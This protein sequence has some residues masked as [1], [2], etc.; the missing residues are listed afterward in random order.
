VSV[1]R[2]SR[3][4]VVAVG[5]TLAYVVAAKLGLRLAFVTPTAT[6]VWPPTGIALAALLVFGTRLWPAVFIGA[7]I[8]DASA[9]GSFALMLALAMGNTLEAVAG[10]WLVRRLARGAQAFDCARDVFG[11]AAITALLSTPISA[12]IGATSLWI[13]G[14]VSHADYGGVWLTWWLGDASAD[15][16]VAPVLILWAIR[17]RLS[18]PSARQ[19]ERIL[20]AMGLGIAGPVIFADVLQEPRMAY[21][22]MFVAFPFLSWAVF[23]FGAREASTAMAWLSAVAIWGV[24]HRLG[25]FVLSTPNASLLLLQSFMALTSV[26]VLST[27]GVVEERNRIEAEL[28]RQA[29]TDPLTGLANYRHLINV[30]NGTLRRSSKTDQSFAV[31]LLDVDNLKTINDRDGHLV[32]NQV[33]CRLATA[34]R[35]ACPA[36]ATV[37]RYGGDEFAIALP[38]SDEDDARRLAT[39]IGEILERDHQA[40]PIAV[41]MGVAVYP[42]DARSAERLLDLADREVYVMKTKAPRSAPHPVV[43]ED[44]EALKS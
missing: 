35:R 10:A 9:T 7:C 11:F 41:S 14:V 12:T 28:Q 34:L 27:A 42:R 23:R 37:T 25:P 32:G 33:L 17:P 31:L 24:V 39:R 16:V 44:P 18:L 8:V 40:P 21:P 43:T 13:A 22:L 15:L 4:F 1:P 30:L 2:P 26:M 3:D 36:A 38:E 19:F 5:V 29:L 6:A 20:L